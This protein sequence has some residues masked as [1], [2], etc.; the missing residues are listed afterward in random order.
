MADSV[1]R[2]VATFKAKPNR[3]DAFISLMTQLRVP[4]QAEPGC[5]VYDMQ[6]SVDDPTLFVFVEQWESKAA[7]DSHLESSHVQEAM[8]AL[9]DML[10]EP[11]KADFFRAIW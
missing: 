1:L 9:M 8:P 6:Q 3:V 5:Y 10:A 7:V 4:T 11:P 2:V